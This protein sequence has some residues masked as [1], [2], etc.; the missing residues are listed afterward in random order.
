MNK[1]LPM[2]TAVVSKKA[3][4]D[5][6]IQGNDY[7]VIGIHDEYYCIVDEEG[8]PIMYPKCYF[9]D[10]KIGPQEGWVFRHFEGGEYWY[11][12]PEFDQTSTIE[13]F[14]DGDPEAIRLFGEFCLKHGIHSSNKP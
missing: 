13:L 4:G 3:K 10:C 1:R 6:L 9:I 7:P 8:E 14:H 11:Y 2:V 5:A 12:P